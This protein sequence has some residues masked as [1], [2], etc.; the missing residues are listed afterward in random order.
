MSTSIPPQCPFDLAG[1]RSSHKVATDGSVF[2]IADSGASTAMIEDIAYHGAGHDHLPGGF[3]VCGSA[4][5]IPVPYDGT[6]SA[7]LLSRGPGGGT[8]L[9]DLG[10]VG[11]SIHD[12]EAHVEDVSGAGTDDTAHA[13]GDHPDG[14]SEPVEVSFAANTLMFGDPLDLLEQAWSRLLLFPVGESGGR[15]RLASHTAGGAVGHVA[16]QWEPR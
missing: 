7:E 15:V 6:Y 8:L 2:T 9:L 10:H 4:V 16:L 11:Q 12:V 1:E 14:W 13:H 5:G 3:S